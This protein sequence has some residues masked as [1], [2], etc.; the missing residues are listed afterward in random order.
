[1][2]PYLSRK[3]NLFPPGTPN[4]DVAINYE[5]M[6]Y[7]ANA[8][9]GADGV[10]GGSVLDTFKTLQDFR[11]RYFPGKTERIAKYYN[12]GDL[13]I[14]REM[15]CVFASGGE[16]ACYV[17]NFAPKDANGKLVFGDKAG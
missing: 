14:G 6:S 3:G 11:N 9:T 1:T 10:S 2:R 17:F 16:S 7:Y 12:R 13:G 15:H 4:R 8:K 5:T